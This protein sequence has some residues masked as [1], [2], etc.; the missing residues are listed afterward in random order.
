MTLLEKISLF[1]MLASML[2]VFVIIFRKFSVL[3]LLNTENIPGEKEAIFKKEIIKKRVDRDLAKMAS[4]FL[5][6][7][8][9]L[10]NIVKDSLS[11]F[12]N[13]LRS[14]KAAYIKKNNLS[15]EK[16]TKVIKDLFKEAEVAEKREDENVAENK[17]LEIIN[18]D[19][20]NLLAFFLLGQLYY[21]NKK[22]TEAIQTL[23]YALKLAVKKKQENDLEEEVAIAEIYFSLAKVGRDMERL[24]YALECIRESLDLEPNNPR[25][26]DLILDLSIIK[27]DKGLAWT[28]FNKMSAINPENNK[29][30]TWREEIMSLSE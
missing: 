9:N 4:V 1:L 6:F 27:K 2:A 15:P 24:D 29:L 8:K 19:Q 3:S 23:S 11:F 28:Y 25:Y 16:K 12:E 7:S 30:Q 26:L 20:K 22:F 17:L 14:L 21:D 18:L 5:I 10:K 13:S